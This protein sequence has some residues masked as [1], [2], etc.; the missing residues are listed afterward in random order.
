MPI[1]PLTDFETARR[2]YLAAAFVDYPDDFAEVLPDLHIMLEHARKVVALLLSPAGIALCNG[3]WAG[4]AAGDD[5][6]ELI[7][8]AAARIVG[9]QAN[10][11]FSAIVEDGWD[12]FEFFR[13]DG[14]SIATWLASGRDEHQH[15][16]VG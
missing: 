2:R 7:V 6:I 1:Q 5:E 10:G 14:W 13:A 8:L 3:I 9:P 12:R 4:G 15:K 16:P 11:F